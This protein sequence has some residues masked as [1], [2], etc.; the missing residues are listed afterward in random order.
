MKG[1]NS[2]M[3]WLVKLIFFLMLLPFFI[4]LVLQ[5]T[6]I[7]FQMILAVFL[8]LLPW[9]IGFAVLVG[10]VAG[11]A[12]GFV[13]RRRLPPRNGDD[14]PPALP[15]VRRPREIRRRDENERR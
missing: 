3:E 11:S 10:L 9:V 12:A 13:L 15:P 1:S 2:L 5:V 6:S 14:M 8:A 7:T 4:S